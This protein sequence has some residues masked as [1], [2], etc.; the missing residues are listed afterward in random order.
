MLLSKIE[1]GG[2]F[3]NTEKETKISFRYLI[4]MA[5]LIIDSSKHYIEWNQKMDD[6]LKIILAYIAVR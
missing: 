1:D 4:P 2:Y 3:T 5:I 6:K